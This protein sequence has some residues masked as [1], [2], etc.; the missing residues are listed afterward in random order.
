MVFEMGDSEEAG[1]MTNAVGAGVRASRRYSMIVE[2][3]KDYFPVLWARS[4]AT[5]W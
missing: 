3:I 5:G 2:T 4:W 1:V